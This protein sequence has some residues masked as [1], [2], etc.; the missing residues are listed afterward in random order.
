MLKVQDRRPVVGKVLREGARGAGRPLAHIANH[1][2]V[3]G[4]PAH[5]LVDMGRRDN[6]GLDNRVEAL[7]TD[8]GAPES[9]GCVAGPGEGGDDAE[10][11]HLCVMVGVHLLQR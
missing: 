2:S 11:L 1:G 10:Q 7:N 3:E 9:Q 6:A 5:D 8:G 4:I